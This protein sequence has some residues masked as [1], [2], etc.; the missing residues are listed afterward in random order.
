MKVSGQD[1]V[2]INFIKIS[3]NTFRK[4]SITWSQ[5]IVSGSFKRWLIRHS[6]AS[7]A[8]YSLCDC[9]ELNMVDQAW[10][11]EV[12][13]KPIAVLY[14]IIPSKSLLLQWLFNLPL[15]TQ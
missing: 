10:I 12:S 6:M 9:G 4:W 8:I 1:A 3:T 13:R 15:V 11:P 5:V 7:T 14:C 2:N